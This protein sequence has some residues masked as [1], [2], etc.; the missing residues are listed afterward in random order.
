MVVDR[1]KMAFP[2]Q[3][4]TEDRASCTHRPHPRKIIPYKILETRVGIA[5]EICTQVSSRS[6]RIPNL[7]KYASLL[8]A[9]RNRRSTISLIG[10]L[11]TVD[12][13]HLVRRLGREKLGKFERISVVLGEFELARDM[14]AEKAFIVL[15]DIEFRQVEKPAL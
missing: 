8:G 15:C 13:A 2:I 6:H 5:T 1:R 4:T 12:R 9:D 14:D 11:V 3:I 7:R 10:H